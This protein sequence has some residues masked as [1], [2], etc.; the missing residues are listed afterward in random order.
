MQKQDS[1]G[2][3][4]ASFFLDFLTKS[5]KQGG[6]LLIDDCL[7]SFHRVDE[8]V[9]VFVPTKNWR[10]NHPAVGRERG[11]TIFG[12]LSLQTSLGFESTGHDGRLFQTAAKSHNMGPLDIASEVTKRFSAPTFQ[13]IY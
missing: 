9:S 8:Q 5:S 6:M 11:R 10:P 3:L 1:L 12:G 7:L 2:Q 13:I 4:V